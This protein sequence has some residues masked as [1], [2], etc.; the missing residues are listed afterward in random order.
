MSGRPLFGELTKD[1][2]PERRARVDVRKAELR[3][4]MSLHELRQARVMTRKGVGEVLEVNQ[5]A[6][7]EFPQ[8]SVI[9]TNFADVDEEVEP[10]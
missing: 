7:A 5:P 9:N 3:A 8:G 4:A 6:V 10:R 2:A 1:F